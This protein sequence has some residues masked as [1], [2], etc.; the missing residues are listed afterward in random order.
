MKPLL[1]FLAAVLI[2]LAAPAVHA[3]RAFA[4]GELESL[5]APIALYPDAVVTQ[6]LDATQYPQDVAAA[7]AWARANP[8]L[9]GD[10]ALAT[11]QGT[12]WAPSVKALAAYPELLARMAESPQWLADLGEA[13]A[14]YGPNVMATVQE[15]RARAQASG[16]LQSNGQQ[17]VTQQGEAIVVQP[18][19]PSVVYLPWY[20]PYVVY[21]GWVWGVRPV[22][23]HPW[24]A[25]PH[26]VTRVV[27]APRAHWFVHRPAQF[28]PEPIRG[29]HI[30]ARGDIVHGGPTVRPFRPVPEAR[31]AP[32][33]HSGG[34]PFVHSGGF[35]ASGGN[36]RPHGG[37]RGHGGRR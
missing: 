18:A 2:G 5:L 9:S 35:A 14:A 10:A 31:R 12:P 17:Y 32:V 22:F 13:Y 33:V 15:L 1:R 27:F 29:P 23:W 11:V 7:A 8:Q 34:T 20:D 19:Y 6:V 30:V 16:Y 25:R 37:A 3:Q 26:I 28:H 36:V 4:P 24:I 21:G